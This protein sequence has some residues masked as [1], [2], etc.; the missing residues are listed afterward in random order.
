MADDGAVPALASPG[1]GAIRPGSP[2]HLEACRSGQRSH[3]V[4]VVGLGECSYQ[5]E[6]HVT[7]VVM[8]IMQYGELVRDLELLVKHC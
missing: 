8:S 2:C 7:I 5:R 3:G 1:L 6:A 4:P